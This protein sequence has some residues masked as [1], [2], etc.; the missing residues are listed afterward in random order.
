[1]DIGTGCAQSIAAP[2]TPKAGVHAD[3][4]GKYL[5]VMKKLRR[6]AHGC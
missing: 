1:V 5:I 3:L 6:M 4:Q 2:E